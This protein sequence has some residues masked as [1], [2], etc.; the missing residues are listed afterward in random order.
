VTTAHV[1]GGEPDLWPA[2]SAAALG[3]TDRTIAFTPFQLSVVNQSSITNVSGPH[4]AV[5]LYAV[6]LNPY[7][8]P[9]AT[10]KVLMA[11]DGILACCS[12]P[13]GIGH[14]LFSTNTSPRKQSLPEGLDVQHEVGHNRGT[15][16]CRRSTFATS[17]HDWSHGINWDLSPTA[18]VAS[19]RR[20]LFGRR[21]MGRT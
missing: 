19:G 14:R 16:R 12:L 8:F 21:T 3:Y 13:R 7:S 2:R 6:W 4:L 11:D 5:S 10:T 1:Q 17:Y 15:S 18:Y 9:L 20:R